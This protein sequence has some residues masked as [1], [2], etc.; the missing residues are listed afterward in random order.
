MSWLSL[1]LTK[2]EFQTY[3]TKKIDYAILG[4][5]MFFESLLWTLTDL[6]RAGRMQHTKRMSR[7]L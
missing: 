6:V 7:T 2:Y 5:Y 3:E 1:T 4:V